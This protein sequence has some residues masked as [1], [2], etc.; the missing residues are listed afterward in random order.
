MISVVDKPVDESDGALR[1]S[2]RWP[3]AEGNPEVAAATVHQLAGYGW[4]QPIFS[5]GGSAGGGR[6]ARFAQRRPIPTETTGQL[7]LSGSLL[8][9]FSFTSP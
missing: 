1:N 2:A 3:C 6:T 7:V 8:V 4:V 5:R 9:M